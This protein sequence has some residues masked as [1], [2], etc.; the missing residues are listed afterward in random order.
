[1]KLTV[2]L[3]EDMLVDIVIA[4]LTELRGYFEEAQKGQNNENKKELKQDI[5]AITAV[6]RMYG[7]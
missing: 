1:M 5:K 2:E 6:L 7:N 4:E 3:S